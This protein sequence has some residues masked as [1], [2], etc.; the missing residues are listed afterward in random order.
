MNIGT[1]NRVCQRVPTIHIA[2][3]D[4]RYPTV[5]TFCHSTANNPRHHDKTAQLQHESNASFDRHAAR[6]RRDVAPLPCGGRSKRVGIARQKLGPLQARISQTAVQPR[7]SRRTP[8]I[9]ENKMGKISARTRNE[10]P[11]GRK[12]RCLLPFINHQSSFL[13]GP[14]PLVLLRISQGLPHPQPPR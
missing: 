10:L 11:G 12:R 7:V 5:D 1:W 3:P 2:S 4:T 8:R 13:S 14:Q 9:A 6:I